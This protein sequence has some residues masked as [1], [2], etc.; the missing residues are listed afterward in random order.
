MKNKIKL[1]IKILCII[2]IIVIMAMVIRNVVKII[3][4]GKENNI[5]GESAVERYKDVEKIS[6]YDNP[7][8]PE[9]FKKIETDTASW[10]LVDGRPEGW[11][12]GLVI[13][14]EQGNQFV[15]VPIKNDKGYLSNYTII[16]N[17]LY[18]APGISCSEK[19]IIQVLKYEGFYVSRYE[20]GLPNEIS[21]NTKEFSIE[22]NNVEGVPVSK[23]NQIVWNFISWDN[24][25]INAQNMYMNEKYKSDLISYSQW[26]DIV[27]WL[28]VGTTEDSGSY[29]NYSNGN[30][31]FT[32]YYSTDY[33][34]S[35][36][37]GENKT[38]ETYNMLLSTGAT[39]RN[40]T[41]N[42]YDLA[43]NVS[44]VVDKYQYKDDKNNLCE[45]F[46]CMGGNYDNIGTYYNVRDENSIATPNSRQG[47]RVVLYLE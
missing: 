35:Y 37:Y 27:Y 23:K 46:Y 8:V 4:S 15:W 18:A 36:Q 25:K 17:Y 19:E 21:E 29:G 14:D 45:A 42:I 31:N 3:N 1:L 38:K 33:G 26:M 16:D 2:V 30:F 44:E 7:I 41:N 11:N 47:F 12:N 20:A 24:A 10:N 5:Q 32:G 28:D 9:G 40:K 6:S 39:D 13:E 22:T 34:K 43:G